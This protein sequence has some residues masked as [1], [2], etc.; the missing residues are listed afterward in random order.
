MLSEWRT[1]PL[2][3]KLTCSRKADSF[4]TSNLRKRLNPLR[5]TSTNQSLIA[6]KTGSSCVT[7]C[8]LTPVAMNDKSCTTAVDQDLTFVPIFSRSVELEPIASRVKGAFIIASSQLQS[9]HR[10]LVKRKCFLRTAQGWKVSDAA[11]QSRRLK[12]R[13]EVSL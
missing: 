10:T 6:L 5:T 4:L 11:H 13:F 9:C 12:C 3:V 8:L 7:S 1:Q 2:G